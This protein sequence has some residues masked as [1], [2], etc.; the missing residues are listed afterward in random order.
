MAGRVGTSILGWARGAR[1]SAAVGRGGVV[2]V[3]VVESGTQTE[4]VVIVG[5]VVGG[6]APW[7]VEVVEVVGPGRARGARWSRVRAA[8]PGGRPWWA[9][10]QVG[11][12]TRRISVRVKPA[13]LCGRGSVK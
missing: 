13:R 2:V 12:S 5:V 1:G 11:S 6:S 8:G 10:E 7:V 9:Q 4:R 3:G